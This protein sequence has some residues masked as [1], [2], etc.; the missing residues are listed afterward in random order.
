LIGWVWVYN[1]IWMVVQDGVKLAVYRVI[2]RRSQ[3]RQVFATHAGAFLE[4]T[5]ASAQPGG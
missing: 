4:H 1:L 3:H 5:N 2:G